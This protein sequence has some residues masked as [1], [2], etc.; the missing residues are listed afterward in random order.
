MARSKSK[1]RLVRMKRRQHLRARKKRQKAARAAA[2][3]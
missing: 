2:K 1:Q 3:G